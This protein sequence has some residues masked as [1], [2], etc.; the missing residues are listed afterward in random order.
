VEGLSKCP[1]CNVPVTAFVRS[2]GIFIEWA[3]GV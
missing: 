2:D 3:V 1:I